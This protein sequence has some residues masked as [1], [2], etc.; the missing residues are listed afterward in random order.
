[1]KTD[2]I[3]EFK[4]AE[5]R[6]VNSEIRMREEDS[7]TITGYAAVFNRDSED[8]GGWVERI[9]PSAF[10]D[11]LED[12]A[13]ALF[14]HDPNLVLAR[15]KVNMA[16]SVDMV[17][18]RYEFDAPNTTVGNDLIENIRN[19]N[20]KQSSFAFTTKEVK[21][22]EPKNGNAV[23]TIMKVERLYDVSPV[24]YPAYP[25]TT[26]A[27]RGFSKDFKIK[28]LKHKHDLFKL[29]YENS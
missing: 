18:L 26:V 23:R 6:F 3:I 16:L 15:N 21:W 2:Y 4:N 29:T 19:G 20:I 22:Y 28:L 27:L 17:G 14:N 9:D 5:R 12:D 10:N 7:R 1:M 11:V 25:D 24:T 8:F 13:L